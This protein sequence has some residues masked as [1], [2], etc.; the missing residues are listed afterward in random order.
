MRLIDIY[1]IPRDVS[2]SQ[3]NFPT[4]TLITSAVLINK[5]TS[6]C[7]LMLNKCYNIGNQNNTLALFTAFRLL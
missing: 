2:H 3:Y 1:L 6:P 5:G 7:Y 4:K